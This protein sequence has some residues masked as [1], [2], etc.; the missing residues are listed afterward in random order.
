MAKINLK[1]AR[2]RAMAYGVVVLALFGAVLVTAVQAGGGLPGGNQTQVR[3]A[4]DEAGALIVGDD[5]RI[6]NVRVGRVSDIA[7][8]GEE[9][10]VTMTLEED[11]DIYRDATADIKARSSLGQKYVDI[12]P[13]DPQQG[14]LNSDAV[15]PANRTDGANDITELIDVLGKPTRDALSTTLREVGGGA[16]GH[17]RDIA[18]A[19][20]VLPGMLNDLGGVSRALT[21]DGGAG[22][23][24]LLATADEL[25]VAFTGH[26]QDL[27]ALNL[28]LGTT[29]QALNADSGAALTEVLDQAPE[30][31][32]ETRS[33]LNTLR[34]PLA[35]TTAAMNGLRPG[36]D[37]LAEAYPDLRSVLRESVRPLD[38]VPAV[39]GQ[40]KPTVDGL[41]KVLD[42]ARPLAPQVEK[43]MSRARQ[44][45]EYMSPYAPEV[46]LY[47][48]YLR[49]ALKYGSDDLGGNWLR[50]IPVFRPENLSGAL[51]VADP[52]VNRNAYPE[53][54]EAATDR[55]NHIPG[56]R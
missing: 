30:A 42:D 35:D 48:K 50:I 44:P 13:G 7:L 51:P 16:I 3:A 17:Q 36:A 9:P 39:V 53:P 56:R 23:E 49:E 19:A 4:F 31:M 15:I 40:A 25:S 6:G 21:A 20:A 55:A 5:V 10:V 28:D 52:T 8:N 2:R 27:A 41:T 43:A 38:K 46:A 37:A 24:S 11:R 26:N 33:A 1:A 34:R 47:F 32:R 14:V 18:D 12:N 54:G 22:L 29:L 45:V